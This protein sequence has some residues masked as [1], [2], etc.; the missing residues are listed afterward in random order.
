M[1]L[2]EADICAQIENLGA[3]V[4]QERSTDK[5]YVYAVNGEMMAVIKKDSNPLQLS[6]RCDPN[7]A[8]LLRSRYESVL[9]GQN[10]NKKHWI[11]VLMT[12]QLSDQYV[13]DQIRHA[14]EETIKLA[15]DNISHS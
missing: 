7:L 13:H 11:T 2:T 6:L 1:A 15:K 4:D 8:K 3:T 5:D 10:L 14:Y 9:E 12:G